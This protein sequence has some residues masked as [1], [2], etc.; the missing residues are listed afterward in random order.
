VGTQIEQIYTW[1]R[2]KQGEKKKQEGKPLIE[3]KVTA[4]RWIWEDNHCACFNLIIFCLK[5]FNR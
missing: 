5:D 1:K 3:I 2:R 4:N